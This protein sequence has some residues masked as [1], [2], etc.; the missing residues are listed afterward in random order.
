MSTTV[1]AALEAATRA[2]SV[3]GVAVLRGSASVRIDDVVIDHRRVS[4]G[5]MYCCL[6]GERHDGHDFAADA[7][8]AG[9]QALL[10]E[11][12]LDLDVPQVV[13][14][15]A[16]SWVGWFAS[17]VHGRPSEKMTVVGVTGTNGKTTCVH[18][19]AAVLRASGLP[20]ETMG[21]LSGARTTPEAD[22][23]QRRLAELER[24]GVRAV[25]M[26]VSSHAL[27]LGRVDATRFA[28]S[29]FTNLGLD[30]LDFHG[31][32][33]AY[34]EA[35]ASL[36][37]A[38]RT[39]MAVINVDDPAGREIER[40]CTEPVR[41]YSPSS[42]EEPWADARAHGF[43]WRGRPVRVA[44]G[45]RFNVENSLAAATCADGIGVSVDDI[46]QGLATAS[47]VPGR[48]E[49]V[50]EHGGASVLVDYAHD[51]ASLERVL[52]AA[53]EV[54]SGRVGVVFGCGGDRDRAKRPEMGR[55][56]AAYADHVIVT[57]DNPR[58][59]DPAA[60]AREI[61]SGAPAREVVVELDRRAAIGRALAWLAPGDV[62]VVA[63]KGH[64]R[65]QE[66]QGRLEPFE[67]A[68]VIREAALVGR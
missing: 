40:R 12:A 32:P 24:S 14:D 37:R 20:T 63:G 3:G 31:T 65:H 2:R 35:K 16:R 15:D 39:A 52:R 34:F 7:V 56:A 28:A 46:V 61:V 43:R 45:G 54:S 67:D 25:A 5:A 27:V 60:I 11:R 64:E 26:E 17:E 23:V 50:L 58:S 49:F 62:L 51:A 48:F 42:V 4:H 53:R 36:F 10:V 21:T 44:I 55:V 19:L 59:E 66:I 57:T 47:P 68:V 18:L 29:V 9:A 30:H 6:R 33:E 8:R 41:T 1:G 38:D 22:D 13:V